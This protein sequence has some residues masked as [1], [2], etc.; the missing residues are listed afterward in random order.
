MPATE[1]LLAFLAATAVFA[2]MPGP[3]MLY[4]AARRR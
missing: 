4:A 2:Y 1:L 3:A